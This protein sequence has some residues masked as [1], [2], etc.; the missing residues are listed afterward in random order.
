MSAPLAPARRPL[1]GKKSIRLQSR[2]RT[3]I[4]AAYKVIVL[5]KIRLLWLLVM[6]VIT[7]VITLPWN[8]IGKTIA[9]QQE[10]DDDAGADD[11]E[12]T[13]L[14][15]PWQQHGRP[16][17]LPPR[18]KA[19]ELPSLQLLAAHHDRP[20]APARPLSVAQSTRVRL[21]I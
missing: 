10:D 21:Q 14:C 13:A 8:T 19:A 12:T 18:Q 15:A 2:A 20:L 16:P 4:L 1:D 6:F 3:R 9:Q 7:P 11:G 17:R 5:R